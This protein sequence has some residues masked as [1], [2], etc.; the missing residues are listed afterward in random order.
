[1]GYK[2]GID[3][4]QLSLLPASMEEYVPQNHICRV[5]TAFTE[6]LDMKRLGYKYAECKETGCNPYDP[7]MM[8]NLY[9]YGYLHRVRSS[10]RLRDEAGRNVEVMWLLDGLR[11]DDKTICNFRKDNRI[12]LQATFRELSLILR[13]LG[14]Y[15][16]ELVATDGVKIRANNSIKNNH[17][18]VVIKNELARTEAKISEYLEALDRADKESEGEHEPSSEEIKAAIEKLKKRERTCKVLQERIEKEGEVSTIDPDARMMYSGGD[19]RKLDVCYNIQTVVDSKHNLI[20]DFKV[21]NCSSDTGNL[22]TLSEQAKTILGVQTL[23]TLADKGYY[24]GEDIVACEQNGITCLVA[25]KKSSGEKKADGFNHGDFIY[26]RERDLYSCPCKQELRPTWNKRHISGRNYQV[27]SNTTA[28]KICQKKALCTKYRYREVYRLLFQD[29][30]DQVDERTR[31]HKALYKKR[32]AIV[33]H[34]FGT[35]K[36]IWGYKQFLC[37]TMPKVAVEMA[38]TYTA[39]N[40]RR[41]F[42]IFTENG[43]RPIGVFG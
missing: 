30:L 5:I 16:R 2:A 22:H 6:Q 29:V 9:I 31:T 12:A 21:T 15:S 3:K 35:I 8:L 33:E 26:D 4:H 43:N 38:L 41:L 24:S 27:Y 23:T 11:P 42:T 20:V 40:L 36:A 18:A 1:M 37:R 17:N 14:L 39:Y 19:G 32:G 25:K 7:R 13:E 28:C 10:R 34:P